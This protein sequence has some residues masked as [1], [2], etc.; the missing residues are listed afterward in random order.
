[1]LQ[2]RHAHACRPF[3]SQACGFG[4][5]AASNSI[6]R[7]QLMQATVWQL[8][9][10]GRH[11]RAA[12]ARP[13][14]HAVHVAVW[15]PPA[16]A[17]HRL[18]TLLPAASNRASRVAVHLVSAGSDAQRVAV[19]W[20]MCCCCTTTQS[21]RLRTAQPTLPTPRTLPPSPHSPQLDRCCGILP[22]GAL[23]PGHRQQPA[24]VPRNLH[25]AG[26]LRGSS[27][28]HLRRCAADSAR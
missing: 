23:R 15:L 2:Q 12:A 21:L 22:S 27:S 1:M 24:T 6:N 4:S 5:A 14:R 20:V 28:C 9:L 13:G 18:H 25:F 3:Q 19:G 26:L 16:A 10:T 11:P 17:G 8:Q 7:L